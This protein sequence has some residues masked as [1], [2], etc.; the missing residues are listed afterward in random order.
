MTAVQRFRFFANHTDTEPGFTL[1][2]F[3]VNGRSNF[4]SVTVEHPFIRSRSENLYG[5]ATLDWREVESRNDLEPTRRDNIRAFRVG[6]RYEFLDTLFGVG[7]NSVSVEFAQGLKVLGSSEEDDAN[8]TRPGADPQFTK[9]S[10]EAQRLQ[11]VTEDV[12]LLLG[13]RGQVSANPL[14]ASEE[15]G[16][17][18]PTFGR[19]FDPSEIIGDDGVAGKVEL[20]WNQPYPWD[21]VDDYQVYSFFDVGRIWN[22]DATTSALKS[23]TISSAGLGL[24]ADVVQDI[25]AGLAV[26]FPL[27]RDVETQRDR[28]PPRLFQCEPQL[29]RLSLLFL[30]VCPARPDA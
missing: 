22:Q 7:V 29:L 30:I 10:G 19:A 21:L 11:R 24:R 18:G 5:Y 16:V 3:D 25:Q 8:L 15:F 27:N 17:G 28:R 20:Q 1:D 4:L 26:A 12:N 2:E 6:G 9:F 13:A 14:L 23:D